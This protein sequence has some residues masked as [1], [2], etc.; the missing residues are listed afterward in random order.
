MVRECRDNAPLSSEGTVP[1]VPFVLRMPQRGLAVT[2]RRLGVAMEA[3]PIPLVMVSSKGKGGIVDPPFK[4]IRM[5]CLSRSPP[6]RQVPE[7]QD[8][9]RLWVGA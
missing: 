8:G 4:T 2:L 5:A 1:V 6:S 3:E 9:T 7:D